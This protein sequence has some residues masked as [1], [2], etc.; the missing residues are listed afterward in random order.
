MRGWDPDAPYHRQVG[1][2]V[3]RRGLRDNVAVLGN[4]HWFAP[5]YDRPHWDHVKVGHLHVFF[6]GE[7]H[8]WV[9]LLLLL[10]LL[11]LCTVLPF[12]LSFPL[13]ILFS[14][15]IPLQLFLN[16]PLSTRSEAEDRCRGY[17]GVNVAR[18]GGNRDHACVGYSSP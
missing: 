4:C 15:K 9:V 6:W 14:L 5:R 18:C 3:A 17:R 7:W 13:S 1:I 12:S 2:E 16:F 11:L 8:V 10:L